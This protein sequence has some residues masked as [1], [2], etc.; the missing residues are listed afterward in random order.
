MPTSKWKL[1]RAAASTNRTSSGS[2]ASPAAGRNIPF[3]S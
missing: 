2:A 1:G 3:K